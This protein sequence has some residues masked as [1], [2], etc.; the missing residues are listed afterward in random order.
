MRQYLHGKIIA[1]YTILLLTILSLLRRCVNTNCKKLVVSNEDFERALEKLSP[2]VSIA[3]LQD[4][5]KLR[6]RFAP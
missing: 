3:E 1:Y 2:S 6:D 4:Y 5:R